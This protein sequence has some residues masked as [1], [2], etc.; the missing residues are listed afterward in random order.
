MSEGNKR[1]PKK[2]NRKG[3]RIFFTILI[4][5]IVIA[6]GTASGIVIGIAKDAPKI[7]PTNISSLLNQTSFILDENGK[8]IEKIQTE[9]YRTIVSLSKIPLHLQDAFIAIEDERFKSH[10][11]VDPR[12]IASSFMDNIK[13]GH[14]VRGASTITQQLARNLYLSNEKKLDRKI[15]EAYLALQIEKALT[16]NQILEGYLNRIYLGQGAYGVQEAAQTYFSKNVEELT[17]AESAALAGIVKGPSK[18]ALY[19]TLRPENFDAEKHIEIGQVNILSEKYIA[20]YNEEPIK[21]QKLVLA[22]M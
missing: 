3:L 11:G 5:I 16:K 21:R 6:A 13:A 19:E 2:K 7:D 17:I 4:M 15:K 18:Y 8:V 12:G 1:T 10:I 20:I 22:K 9:E 14:T